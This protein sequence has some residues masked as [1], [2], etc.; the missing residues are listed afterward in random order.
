MVDRVGQVRIRF[1]RY[2]FVP[3]QT[4]NKTIIC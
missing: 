3:L 2:N 1:C 4:A